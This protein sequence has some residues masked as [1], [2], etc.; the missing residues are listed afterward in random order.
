MAA[1]KGT[2]RARDAAHHADGSVEPE[3]A[4][5]RWKEM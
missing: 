3:L 5:R 1:A 2:T 4:T